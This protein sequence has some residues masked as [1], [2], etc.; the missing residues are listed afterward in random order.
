MAEDII[1]AS[2]A[3][4][5]CL[6]HVATHDAAEVSA[7]DRMQHGINGGQE[8]VVQDVAEDIILANPAMKAA[9]ANITYVGNPDSPDELAFANQIY[10]ALYEAYSTQ[11]RPAR[12]MNG[13]AMS[14]APSIPACLCIAFANQI[15]AALYEAYST[16]ARPAAGSLPES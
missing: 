12:A 4:P 11:A 14:T 16:Q 6:L 2:P 7:A 3:M 9:L 15:Y 5:S 10:A 13:L 1:L 8:G